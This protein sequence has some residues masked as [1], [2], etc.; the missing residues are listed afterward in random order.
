MNKLLIIAAVIIQVSFFISAIWT[1]WFDYFFFSS[2]LHYCCQGLDFYQI[3]N[4]AFAFFHHGN[5]TGSLS[6]N[7]QPYS[8][9]IFTN[10]NIYHPL[11]TIIL[12]SFFLLFEA[13][14][15][16]YLWMGVK[17]LINL[18]LAYYLYQNFKTN[19][20]I[21]LALFIFLA[22]IN[23]YND[24]KISQ[25]QYLVNIFLFLLLL[26]ISQKGNQF[27]SGFLYFLTLL[28]KP[29]GIFW[30]PVLLIKKQYSL[31]IVGLGLFSVA[32]I[33]FLVN[34]TGNYY[35]D[36]L[37]SHFTHPI[38]VYTIDNMSLE[39]ILRHTFKISPNFLFV[40]KYLFLGIITLLAFSKKVDLIKI[41]YLLTL[42]FLFFYDQ[43][44]QYHYSILIPVFTVGLLT[45]KDFQSRLARILL[46]IISLPH[47]FFILRFLQIGV[48]FDS[49]LGMDPTWFGWQL[50]NFYQI[51]LLLL[52]TVVIFKNDK[53][54]LAK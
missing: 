27:K 41:I 35:V 48:R 14:L 18:G 50:T 23:Q 34:G 9:D 24:I 45:C 38:L 54:I 21:T 8:T 17:L 5:L 39:T 47:I 42:Y 1:H 31:V 40:L 28:V 19:K 51:S 29:I 53:I 2:S 20:F 10:S 15:V 16:F 25:Y 26:V 12:G 11:L 30:A 4:G 13:K 22:S 32:T 6:S 43:I 37:W 36:N 7:N 52:L 44:Y 3:P 49:F 46:F 33:P